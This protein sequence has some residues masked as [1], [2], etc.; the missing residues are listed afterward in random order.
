MI[1]D[2]IRLSLAPHVRHRFWIV[3]DLQQRQPQRARTCMLTAMD[4]FVSL[5]LEPELVCY[6][7]DATEGEDLS[8]I[9]EMARMQVE[10]FARISCPVYYTVGNHDFDYFRHHSDSLK[11]MC[12][13]FVEYVRESPQWHVQERYEQ[14]WGLVDLGDIALCLLTDHADAGGAW[15]TTHGQVRGNADMYPYSPEDYRK[16]MNTL[17]S[18]SKPVITCSHY[19]FAGGNRAA[20]LFD[21][22]LPLAGNVRMH[23][24]GHAHV[25]DAVWAGKDANRKISNVDGQP[26]VQVD[27]ASLESGRGSAV[28]SVIFEWYDTDEVGVFFRNHSLGM[29]DDA[30]FIRAGDCAFVPLKES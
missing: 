29:W 27:V 17:E 25:G 11:G 15:F 3:S 22:F 14:M 4:D 8:H 21:R 23:F 5:D 19:A 12:I 20:P 2:D 6:L 16:V 13:P 10:Q 30:L 28:R 26:V 24:Y 7:G 1:I 18:L 9:R